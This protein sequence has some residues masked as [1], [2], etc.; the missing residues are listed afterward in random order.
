MMKSTLLHI[1]T[2]VSGYIF[3]YIICPSIF[4]IFSSF[5]NTISLY[6]ILSVHCVCQLF[7]SMTQTLV[8]HPRCTDDYDSDYPGPKLFDSDLDPVIIVLLYVYCSLLVIKAWQLAPGF[9]IGQTC[10]VLCLEIMLLELLHMRFLLT[11]SRHN[12]LRKYF[13]SLE[14]ILQN[15]KNEKFN[16]YKNY[17]LQLTAIVVIRNL[18]IWQGLQ[19]I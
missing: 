18:L 6:L 3:L 1:F 12:M 9:M 14:I 5:N 7:L 15:E 17:T 10:F 11:T 16:L 19:L 2:T 8:S 4:P 13:N